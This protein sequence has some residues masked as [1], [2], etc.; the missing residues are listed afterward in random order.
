MVSKDYIYFSGFL[1]GSTY[2]IGPNDSLYL[3]KTDLD[4]EPPSGC[5]IWNFLPKFEVAHSDAML[6][7]TVTGM[8]SFEVS[9]PTTST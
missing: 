1:E 2:Q 6:V 5:S 8:V 9:T 4:L 3:Y 7:T